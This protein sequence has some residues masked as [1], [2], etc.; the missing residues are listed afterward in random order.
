M[1]RTTIQLRQAAIVLAAVATVGL[2]V[3]P[4]T[5]SEETGGLQ[6]LNE[7]EWNEAKARHLLFRAG[8]GNTPEEMARL[9]ALDPRRAVDLLVDFH[10][11]P[12][13]KFALAIE[14]PRPRKLI[15]DRAALAKLKP[16]DRKK[17][18]QELRKQQGDSRRNEREQF[19]DLREWWIRQ[20]GRASCRERV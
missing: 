14:S 19:V 12:E 9:H 17:R 13:P 10:K 3:V 7:Q 8:F 2:A 11:Q 1:R 20:I 5:R 6:P 4:S 16:E 18:L 15:I